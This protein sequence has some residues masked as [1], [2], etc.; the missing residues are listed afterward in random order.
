MGLEALG[1]VLSRD[2]RHP[3]HGSLAR[4]MVSG[5]LATLAYGISR[6][7]AYLVSVAVW[8]LIGAARLALSGLPGNNGAL[9]TNG[10]TAP[11]SVS[12]RRRP[13][14]RYAGGR[15]HAR[16][17][18]GRQCADRSSRAGARLPAV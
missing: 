10:C 15:S 3:C 16:N 14:L 6:L 9:W 12:R 2:D 1:N 8:P 18:A 17:A 5:G 13:P 11:R 4:H 7:Y